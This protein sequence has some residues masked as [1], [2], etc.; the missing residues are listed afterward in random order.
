ME[1]PPMLKVTTVYH[2]GWGCQQIYSKFKYLR[3]AGYPP[4]NRNQIKH[5][6]LTFSCHKPKNTA[7]NPIADI[8]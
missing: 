3:Y 8:I 6:A 4:N 1:V 7:A 2:V 5:P